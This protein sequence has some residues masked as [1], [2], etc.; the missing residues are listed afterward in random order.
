MMYSILSLSPLS[1]QWNHSYQD[2]DY[3]GN[4]NQV[5]QDQD[6]YGNRNYAYDSY[7]Y[8]GYC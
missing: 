8:Q 2:Q 3:Y 6:Y 1:V 7:R 4:E 5:Y